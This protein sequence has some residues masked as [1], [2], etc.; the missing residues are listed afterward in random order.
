VSLILIDE[1]SRV[2][3]EMY[4][5]LRPM[6]AVGGGDLWLMSTPCGQRGFFYDAWRDGAEAWMRLSVP[7][8]ECSRIT[9]E[10]LDG[11]RSRMGSAMFSQEYMCEFTDDGTEYFDRQLGA[12]ALDETVTELQINGRR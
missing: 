12:D 4:E 3:D 10:F 2:Q 7:A 5:A 9:A 11:E 6:L 1:A 8:T